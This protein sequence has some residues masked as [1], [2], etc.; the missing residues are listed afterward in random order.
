MQRKHCS[1]LDYHHFFVPRRCF[2]P[3]TAIAQKG[4]ERA[5]GRL[6]TQHRLQSGPRTLIGCEKSLG[7]M[8][9]ETKR[10]SVISDQIIRTRGRDRD[11]S[12]PKSGELEG[13]EENQQREKQIRRR[14]RIQEGERRRGESLQIRWRCEK[15]LR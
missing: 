13:G 14:I 6:I 12:V 15:R 2:S 10:Q 9:M 3:I 5:G 7:R 4:E 8:L 11:S 1:S